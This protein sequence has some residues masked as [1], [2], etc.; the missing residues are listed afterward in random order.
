MFRILE[1]KGYALHEN[2]GQAFVYTAVLPRKQARQSAIRRLVSQL[3]DDSQGLL[4]LD[5]IEH[6]QRRRKRAR[7]AAPKT[8]R[9]PIRATF[10]AWLVTR[11]RCVVC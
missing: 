11:Y 2:Q 10:L 4:V 3:L 1:K 6:N 5:L 9:Q 8:G 7:P